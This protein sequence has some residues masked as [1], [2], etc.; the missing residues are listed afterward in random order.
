MTSEPRFTPQPGPQERFL[1]S[2]AD[3]VIFGGAAG[4]GKTWS[5]LME[6]LY[7][8]DNPKFGAVLFRRTYPEIVIEGG[9]WDESE[10]IYPAAGGRP[11]KGDLYWTFPS[12]AKVTFSHLQYEKNL[13][14][15]LG[16]QIPLIGMDQLELFT[17]KM[18]FYLLSR[19]RSTAGLSSYF[20]ATCNPEPGWLADFLDWWIA[21]DGYANMDRAGRVRYFVRDDQGEITWGDSRHELESSH[22]GTGAKSVTF[23]PSTIHDNKI[24]LAKDPGYLASLQAL[25]LVERARMLGDPVRGGNWRIKDSAGNVFNRA[26]FKI[27]DAVPAGGTV[28]RRWDFAATEKELTK[29]DPDYTASCLMLRVGA[30]FYILDATAEQIGPAEIERTFKNT[31]EQD[32]ARCAAEEREYLLR[33]EME[34]GSAGK[35][36]TYRLISELQGYD[37]RGIKSTGDKI[38]RAKP[39]AVQAEAGNV[40]L[41][42]GPWIERWLTQMNAIPDWPH[43]DEM[44][45]AAG[46]YFD[47]TTGRVRKA[48]SHQG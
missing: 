46:A 32:R 35:R 45:A 48:T 31:A 9:M 24:L 15:Y 20:R 27:V 41:L 7:H 23:I 37:A 11:V 30:S 1:E 14:D 47:L 40:Y 34:G 18:F 4:G 2:S 21:E 5:L 3:I 12:G 17:S 26:W 13:R 6:P 29:A 28:V 16:A 10:E 25:P 22:P 44:D 38:T 36:D 39:L 19:N 33:W 43:D 42:R 8:I